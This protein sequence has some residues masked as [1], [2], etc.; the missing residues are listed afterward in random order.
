MQGI[1]VQ[2]AVKMQKTGHQVRAL[3]LFQRFDKPEPLL[4]M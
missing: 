1:P 4:G 2:I 3:C